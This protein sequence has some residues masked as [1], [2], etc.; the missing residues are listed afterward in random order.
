REHLGALR[1]SVVTFLLAAGGGRSGL[2]SRRRGVISGGGVAGAVVHPM[3]EGDAAQFGRALEDGVEALGDADRR[4][5]LGADKAREALVRE[6][7][8]Q[9]VARGRRGLG[10]KAPVPV[11][12]VERIGDLRLRPVERPGGA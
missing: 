5:V 10:R 8:E 4:L 1:V 3:L 9:P 11:G 2:A 6:M 7:R 12:L